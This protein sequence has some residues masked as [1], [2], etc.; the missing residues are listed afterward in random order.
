MVE[1]LKISSSAVAL[2]EGGLPVDLAVLKQ[3]VDT[4]FARLGE[5]REGMPA[6]VFWGPWL[7]V[8][9]A[10][11]LELFRRWEKLGSRRPATDD[12]VV[13]GPTVFL[14]DAER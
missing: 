11:A 7:I 1:V 14:P 3:H 10:A 13:L 9:S 4:F 5:A 6:P 8:V 2:L 12:E